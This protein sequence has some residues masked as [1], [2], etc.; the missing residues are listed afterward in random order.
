MRIGTFNLQYGTTADGW[1]PSSKALVALAQELKEEELDLLSLQEADRLNIRSNF[2]DQAK[3][4]ADELRMYHH[5]SRTTFGT[6]I[7]ILSRKPIT[8]VHDLELPKVQW[9]LRTGQKGYV[10][11]LRFKPEQPRRV[12]YLET[13]DSGKPLI[14][15]STH[16]EASTTTLRV[17][18]A[19]ALA[20]F[21][22]VARLDK[23]HAEDAFEEGTAV[24]PKG[25]VFPAMILAGDFNTDP[26]IVNDV[27]QHLLTKAAELVKEDRPWWM[28]E[29]LP[30]FAQLAEGLTFPASEPTKQIDH[31]LGVG[32]SAKDA[33]T[34]RFTISDH[35]GLF[36]EV[37]LD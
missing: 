1:R 25:G 5:F 37:E 11:G 12:T 13:S 23:A 22:R 15:A 31:L 16:L 10:G 9:A 21:A 4:L 14:F 35:L 20:G 3:I 32:V 8:R 27:S 28:G 26:G 18:L 34:R 36:A 2:V 29:S 19:V 24:T 6:G 7:A 17:Q 30:Q 33:H